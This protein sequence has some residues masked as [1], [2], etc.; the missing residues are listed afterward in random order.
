M[1]TGT[2][3]RTADVVNRL[4]GRDGTR[5]EWSWSR[6]PHTY[7]GSGCT[8]ASAIAAR[9]VLGKPMA[10]AVAEAQAY[11]WETLSRARRTGRCQLTPNRLYT[12]DRTEP[13][14]A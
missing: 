5:L 6:L 7:H 14:P 13:Q 4:Y 1:I 8:L 10:D 3:A 12:L 9:L 11:T 2:H